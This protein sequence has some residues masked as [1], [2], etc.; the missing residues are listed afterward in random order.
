MSQPGRGLEG[1]RV[2]PLS[3]GLGATRPANSG[4][5]T[6]TISLDAAG[7][8]HQFTLS[9]H[10]SRDVSEILKRVAKEYNEAVK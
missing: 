2:A 4:L 1:S 5:L 9:A 8:P 6:L 3:S 10:K 7:Q